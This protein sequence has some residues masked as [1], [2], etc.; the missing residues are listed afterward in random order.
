MIF[1]SKPKIF[2]PLI[3]SGQTSRIKVQ[4][5]ENPIVKLTFPF[6]NTTAIAIPKPQKVDKQLLKNSKVPPETID[7]D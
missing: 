5:K 1:Q 4:K 3:S 6:S 2:I 7:L